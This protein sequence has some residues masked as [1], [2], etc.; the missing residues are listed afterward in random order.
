MKLPPQVK[1]AQRHVLLVPG[2]QIVVVNLLLTVKN[3]V[4]SSF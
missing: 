3:L 1:I 2:F 4:I